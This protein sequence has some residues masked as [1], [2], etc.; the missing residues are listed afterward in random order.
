MPVEAVSPWP[1][2]EPACTA[3]GGRCMA[4]CGAISLLAGN[5]SQRLSGIFRVGAVSRRAPAGVVVRLFARSCF[6]SVNAACAFVRPYGRGIGRGI[7]VKRRAPDANSRKKRRD[8][9]DAAAH[10]SGARC[11]PLLAVRVLHRRNRVPPR[12]AARPA[13]LEAVS[14]LRKR[15]S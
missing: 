7:V 4:A 3:E 9:R 12:A 15:L 14:Y 1:A 2:G 11:P 10:K 5:V 6:L 13:G 8:M